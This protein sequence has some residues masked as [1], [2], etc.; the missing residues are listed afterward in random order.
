MSS[1]ISGPQEEVGMNRWMSTDRLGWGS[2]S[3]DINEAVATELFPWPLLG[4]VAPTQLSA[5]PPP[6]VRCEL[7]L[8]SN[9]SRSPPSSS[10]TPPV[11]GNPPGENMAATLAPGHRTLFLGQLCLPA[12]PRHHLLALGRPRSPPSVAPEEDAS[13][14]AKPGRHR[15]SNFGRRRSKRRRR[16]QE[17][18]SSPRS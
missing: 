13:L 15:R 7:Y 9:L 12:T 5:G 16:L 6:T 11:R 14:V 8:S 3:W 17:K 4:A 18:S 2:A 10:R 1:I